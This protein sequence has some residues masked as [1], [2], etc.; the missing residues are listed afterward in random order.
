MGQKD[1]W[2]ITQKHLKT[3]T[4]LV[5]KWQGVFGLFDWDIDVSRM[6]LG[7]DSGACAVAY[8]DLEA[9]M[10][11]I[12]LNANW[13]LRPTKAVLNQA[14]FHEILE[15]FIEPLRYLVRKKGKHS[16]ERI[17]SVVHSIIRR[18]EHV[19]L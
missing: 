12:I 3:F 2:K 7:E 8:A 9:R 1:N 5:R 11:E 4:A 19:C 16:D 15:V 13:N 17:A 14:A 6:D 18:L 10:A